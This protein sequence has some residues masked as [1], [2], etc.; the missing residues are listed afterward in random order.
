MKNQLTLTVLA[1]LFIIAT[2]TTISA[3]KIGDVSL[4]ELQE[5]QNPMDSS[6]HAAY[7]MKNALVK[8]DFNSSKGIMMIIEHRYRI[9]IYDSEGEDYANFEIPYY[10]DGANKEKV[11]KIKAVTV[12]L[13]DGKLQKSKLD[14]KDIYTEETTGN[15]GYKKFAMPDVKKGCVIDVSYIIRTPYL[16]TIPK[17]YFQDYIP[18]KESTFTLR[19]PEYF[20]FNPVSSGFVPLDLE[21][22]EIPTSR[23]SQKEY[24]LRAKD[25]EAFESD[26]FILNDNDY[27]CG[28]KY[29]LA[30]VEFPNT[31]IEYY[32]ENWNEISKNLDE[33]KMLG[34]A[35]KK[36]YKA[37]KPV[38]VEAQKLQTT[39]ERIRYL[40]DYVQSNYSWN[41]KYQRG[42]ASG[43]KDVIENGSGN[44]AELNMIFI[45]L[46]RKSN[47][48]AWPIL[49]KSR[50][51][52]II[53]TNYPS[54]TELNYMLTYVETNDEPMI[55]DA[56]TKWV[57]M[58]QLPYRAIN[59]S[60]LLLKGEKGQIISMSN[61]NMY[62][63]QTAGQYEIDIEENRLVG[64]SQR[65]RSKYA[66]TKYRIDLEE[67][68]DEDHVEDEGNQ[69]DDFQEINL[70]NIYTVTDAKDV[71]TI[72]KSIGIKVDE[73]LY[74]C[75]RIIGDKIFLD[76][77]LDF[78]VTENP[79]TDS[80]RTYPVFYPYL[81]DVKNIAIITLPE[82]YEI[83]SK[84]ENLFARTPNNEATFSYEIKEQGDKLMIYHIIKINT[85]IVLPKAYEG[86]KNIYD[87]MY[88]KSKE[89]I[90]LTKSN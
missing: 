60:G 78:G 10:E 89:K 70:D 80:T 23:Y 66:A 87:M 65:K 32:S 40:Y 85:D 6:A 46:L 22:N 71:E 59:I 67:E 7:L 83:E 33:S 31:P 88:D 84:P 25:V 28:V 9:K 41:K 68:E 79:F 82:G 15:W 76:A 45:Y 3:Q 43:L 73:E 39:Q 69:D 56:S 48:L 64:K 55:L 4:E 11:Q 61:P 44:V 17:W 26:K 29:E 20:S 37:L 74:T 47:V 72:G 12:Y 5:V 1:A 13:E 58:G 14:K 81:V 62:K 30:T 49:T 52:G 27:R 35:L 75:S 90:I 86:V 16:Y 8:Y 2:I 54:V 42:T 34:G 18:V 53:N 57:P 19:V 24:I 38:I 63:M 51:S 36:K 77:A 21:T 50:G